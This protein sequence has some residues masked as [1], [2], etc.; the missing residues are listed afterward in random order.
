MGKLLFSVLIPATLIGQSLVAVGRAQDWRAGT[1]PRVELMSILFR[2]AGNQEYNGCR[3]PLY[4][5][6]IDRYFAPYRD[7]EAVRLARALAGV[8]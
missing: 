5:Q 7:H 1:D 6:A 2:L 8:Y 4:D 3:V